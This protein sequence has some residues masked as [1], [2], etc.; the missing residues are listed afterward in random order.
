M[1]LEET[2]NESAL[3]LLRELSGKLPRFSDGRVNF[4]KTAIAPVIT[5]FVKFKDELLLLKRS[6][7][8]GTYRGLWH[9]IGGYFDEEKSVR[10]KALEELREELGI[11]KGQVSMIQFGK[12]AE[13]SD[14]KIKKVWVVHPVLVELSEKP[15]VRLDWEHTEYKWVR[16]E[17]I[18][19]FDLMPGVEEAL[20]N[21]PP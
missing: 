20:Q 3:G 8:V 7:K 14:A 13:F 12:P 9:V 15:E 1:D 2:A 10:Q 16:K 19:N 11:E 4:S 6:E 21:L 18:K 17:D 5:V